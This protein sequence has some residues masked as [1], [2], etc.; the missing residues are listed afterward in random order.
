LRPFNL[1]GKFNLPIL[2]AL[3]AIILIFP[4][5]ASARYSPAY[6]WYTIRTDHF[7]IYYPK[8]HE[9][10]AQ[11]VL[12]LCEKVHK[13]ITGYLG[14]EPRPCP[15]V[16]DPGTDIFN[17]YQS[18][19]PTRISL[20]ETP[21]YSLR[22]VDSGSDLMDSVFTHEYTHY[23]HITTRLGWYGAL[24]R[25]LGEGLAVS[26]ILS[27]GWVTEG[28]TTN[29][30]TLFTDGGR[31]RSPL[32]KGEMRSFTEGPG[33]WNLNSAAVAS[34][35]APPARRIYL[36]G[37]HMVE[38]L[39]RTYG[40]DTFARISRYQAA[41]PLGGT[42]A[43]IKQVIGKSPQQFY[44]DFLKDYLTRAILIKKEALSAGLP[45]GKVVLAE[46]QN[47][48]SYDSHFWTEK[49]IIT[50]LRRGYDRKTAMVEVDPVTG[51]ILSEIKTGSLSNL[52]AR[53]LPGGRL[54]LPEIFYHPLG[55]GTI[56]TTDLVIYDP[57]T[58]GHKRLTRSRHIYAADLS[59]DGKTLV[60]TRRNGMWS[61]LVL[62]DA[63]GTNLRPLIS[64]PGLYFDAPCW[65]PDR[66]LIAAVLK[67]GGNSDLVLVDPKTGAMELL[68]KSDLAEDHGPEFSPDGKWII[69]SSDRSGIWNIY[70]WDLAGKR[71]F[72]LTSVPY[73]AGD[74]HL[75]P[76]GKTLSYSYLSR[77][78]KQIHILPFNPLSGKPIEVE[79][80]TAV[81]PPDLKR[82]QPEVDFS[83]T[84]GIPLKAYKPFVHIPYFSSDE[85][86]VQA[87]LYLIG[88]DPVGINT[89][90]VRLPYGFNSGRPGYDINLANNSFWPTLSARIYDTSLEGNTIGPGKYFWFRE[91]GAELSAG[92][93]IIHRTVPDKITSSIRLGSRL[94]HFNSLDDKLQISEDA[95]QSVS[96]F[97]EVM[98]SRRP[99]SVSRDMVSS[100]GQ[101][102]S[103]SYEKGLSGLGGEL[104]GSN[105]V[106]SASR[107]IPSWLKHQGLALTVTYQ[108]QQ[109]PLHY[110]KALSLP[111][112]YYD[113]DTA[114]GL[115]KKNNLLMSAEY[116][117]PIL[118]TDNGLGLYA[119]H[120]HLLKGSLFVDYGAGWDGGFDWDAWNQKA[121]TTFGATLTNKFV[122]FAVLP[123]DLVIQVGYKAR[124][125]A[126]FVNFF[127]RTDLL[128]LS[129]F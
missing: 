21:P 20:Y 34:P 17:G 108:S 78:V 23:V 97:G 116:H 92:L 25:I 9:Q 105:M 82:L 113:Q 51:K 117:F 128:S 13:D 101:D 58:K 30:E 88:A 87:G 36:A 24:T 91:R 90:S 109:G 119:Y 85:K 54:L 122:L 8:G 47:L 55:E 29:T 83:G 7:T 42:S 96:L 60:A 81:E 123:I 74:P 95:N 10:A 120:S 31:G 63:N 107:Y 127:F 104:P 35:Y 77:G 44:Q 103:L 76:D 125:G 6:Q 121:R 28:I 89:Y 62:L 106:V 59:P 102:F 33:L 73:A 110:N 12:Q 48:D 50:T 67:N 93:N 118:Y 79:R 72:Q 61:D 26:N 11:R 70:A 52:S 53:R 56:D 18:L 39:N 66:S 65:S 37:Y 98:L 43:A 80:P 99:D 14:V 32:F 100:W 5:G 124:E 1:Q 16:L 112:G 2:L 75:S 84:K 15:I 27:P 49:G 126:G 94:R 86:G 111:R 68:F 41:H 71:L 40:Q 19:F 22:G 4:S 64:Q 3:A 114:G 38:Y 69:F 115:D 46:D 45:P 57:K 129:R